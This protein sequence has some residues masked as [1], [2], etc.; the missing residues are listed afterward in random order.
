MM[1]KNRKVFSSEEKAELRGRKFYVTGASGY[2]GR[3]ICRRLAALGVEV[4]GLAGSL[5][6]E[7]F[8]PTGVLVEQGDILD[9]QTLRRWLSEAEPEDVL[10]HSAAKISVRRNAPY[11]ERVNL[12]GTKNIL[13]VFRERG[14]GRLL[15]IGSVDALPPNLEGGLTREPETF[16]SD[17]LPTSY[18]R[19]KAEACRLVAEAAEDGLHTC[20]LLPS[21][22]AGP[23]DYRNG[24][25]STM[26]QVYLSVAPR[27]SINGG[28]E[29]VD[30]RDVADSVIAAVLYG[31][32]GDVYILSNR[33]VSVTE[34]FN[35][36]AS[37]LGR[38]PVCITFPLDLLYGGLPFIW[39]YY[40]IKGREPPLS[41]AAIAL[42]R[43]P[44]EYDHSLAE[45]KLGFRPRSIRDTITDEV[46]FL[47]RRKRNENEEIYRSSRT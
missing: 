11:C 18:G 8:W 25:I 17:G 13:T 38:K 46:V 16:S 27:F 26:L 32:P 42:M 1:Q 6:S 9:I 47:L 19:S 20:I 10:I 45:Q 31:E 2:V 39:A 15:Y 41:V 12:E 4:Y 40:R 23:G 35:V 36:M 44:P 5:Q 21:A 14:I 30:V 22:I 37:R 28:Y 29:F 24:F 34:I 33:Y 7:S 3:E 43:E